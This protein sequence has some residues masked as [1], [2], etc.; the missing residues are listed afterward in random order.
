MS[1]DIKIIVPTNAL[2]LIYTQ[3]RQE[4]LKLIGL[5]QE[6]LGFDIEEKKSQ[7][8]LSSKNS[9]RLLLILVVIFGLTL[10]FSF[11]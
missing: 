8:P 9:F 3:K 2:Y 1:G 10:L 6:N 4:E 5:S 11:F 7:A